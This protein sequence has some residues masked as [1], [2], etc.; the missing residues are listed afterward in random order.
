MNGVALAYNAANEDY[1]GNVVVVPGGAVTLSVTVRGSIFTASTTQ[2]TS[3]PTLSVPAPGDTW[4]SSVANTVMWSGG[5]PTANAKY[6][7]GILDAADPNGFLVWP[8]SHFVEEFPLATTSRSI[9]AVNITGGNRLVIA[10]I[11]SDTAIS[12]AAPG[13]VLVVEGFDYVPITVTGLPVTIRRSDRTEA[14]QGVAWS[15][16]QFVAVG[17]IPGNSFA[18][19]VGAILT[20]PDGITWT[21]RSS[22][23]SAIL[24]A[25]ASSGT[26][27][28][29]VGQNATVGGPAT[30]LTSSDGISWTP[31]VS[32]AAGGL[33][34]VAWSGSQFVAVGSNPAVSGTILTSPD[35][36]TW[37]SRA[38]G[39]SSHI[40]G[41][42]WSDTQFVAVGSGG[43]ILTSPDGI[44]WTPRTSGTI[45]SLRGVVWS[46]ALFVA[47]GPNSC[48]GDVVLTSPDG[49]AW[50][51]RS[52]G[53]TWPLAVAWSGTE[54]MAV[55]WVSGGGGTIITSPDGVT[56]TRRASG[57]GDFLVGIVWSGT[58]FVV[59]GGIGTILTSP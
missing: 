20:S 57:T 7:L 5:A 1:E 6:V 33:S 44:A 39:T 47:V 2:F 58:K 21:S 15:G 34:G 49:I 55:G 3:Y 59:V 53:G 31:R 23:T 16:T 37:T 13:S 56:W 29:V 10:G 51:Q 54:F 25:V 41:V 24:S 48:C 4:D 18:T 14:L 12:N 27:F 35:G 40:S 45:V 8:V 30:I 11:S 9:S 17:G 52:S 22:G 28:V 38:S 43:L 19:N 32:G 46:G 42:I 36:I 50:T 26:Q